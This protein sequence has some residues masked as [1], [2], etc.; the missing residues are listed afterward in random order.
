MSSPPLEPFIGLYAVAFAQRVGAAGRVL[1]FEPDPTNFAALRAH[2]ELNAL[3]SRVQLVP[4]AVGQS[5]G[6]GSFS[7]DGSQS[8]LPPRWASIN[9]PIDWYGEMVARQVALDAFA[10]K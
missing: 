8:S 1:A 2:V 10:E 3:G 5:E 9:S 4:A 6:R 7:V